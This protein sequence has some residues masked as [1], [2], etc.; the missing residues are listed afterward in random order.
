M[1]CV[2]REML[3]ILKLKDK[4]EIE[5][6]NRGVVDAK[7]IPKMAT[8]RSRNPPVKGMRLSYRETSHPENGRPISELTGIK[9]RMVPNSASL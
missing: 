8:D 5:A 2:L 7:P 1:A 6:I 9:S 3:R 4:S